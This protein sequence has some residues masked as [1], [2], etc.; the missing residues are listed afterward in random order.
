M[1]ISQ[2]TLQNVEFIELRRVFKKETDDIVKTDEKILDVLK[3]NN[4]LLRDLIDKIELTS[5]SKGL[6]KFKKP[7]LQRE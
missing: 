6:G 2:Q 7:R 3:D 5:I 4:A 1:A